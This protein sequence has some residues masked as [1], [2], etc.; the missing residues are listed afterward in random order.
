MSGD[1]VVNHGLEIE[2][3]RRDPPKAKDFP[4]ESNGKNTTRVYSP[5][6]Y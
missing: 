3:L 4:Q 1:W 2:G 6:E 5:R